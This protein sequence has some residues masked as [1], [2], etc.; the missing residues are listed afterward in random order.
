[1]VAIAGGVMTGCGGDDNGGSSGTSGTS[2]STTGSSG[3]TTGSTGATTGSTGATTGATG[4]T[5]GATGATGAT[6]AMDSGTPDA[7]I[8]SGTKDS[9]PDTGT[10]DAGADADAATACNSATVLGDGGGTLL[11]SFG[12]GVI[13]GWTANVQ[14]P[15]GGLLADGG[16]AGIATAVAGVV[17]DGATCPGALALTTT[18][19]DYGQ[20]VAAEINFNPTMPITA[21]TVHMS[22]KLVI[23]ADTD[24][25]AADFLGLQNIQ[26]FVNGHIG[27]AGAYSD[28]IDTN[29]LSAEPPE[30]RVDAWDDHVGH[31]RRGTDLD[32]H[33]PNRRGPPIVS[34]DGLRSPDAHAGHAPRRRHLV[35]IVAI[36]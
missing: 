6:G 26:V 25:S 24:G 3:S 9:G 14:T 12:N 21:T 19:T 10:L 22:I 35:R 2:G 30:R 18:F 28:F 33:R 16:S 29:V 20:Q 1:M 36:R 31:R 32:Q 5:S 17:N 23:P 13:T 4:T 8:D 15:A 11:Y 34:G 7:T 27:D